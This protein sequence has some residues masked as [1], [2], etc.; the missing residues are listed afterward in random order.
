M[1]PNT[2]I[3]A[4]VLPPAT[5]EAGPTLCRR[6]GHPV[7]LDTTIALAFRRDGQ[8]VATCVPCVRQREGRR[9]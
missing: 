6:C 9:V 2:P 3:P 1:T 4:C 8:I 5:L 7:E